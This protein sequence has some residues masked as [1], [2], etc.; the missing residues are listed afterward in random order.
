MNY[1][2]ETVDGIRWNTFEGDEHASA[3]LAGDTVASVWPNRRGGR[4]HS[5]Q[6]WGYVTG[7]GWKVISGWN[8]Q[9]FTVT[10]NGVTDSEAEARAVAARVGRAL[11]NA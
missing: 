7:Y 10:A 1:T 5:G 2:T 9:E 8:G 3:A 6:E 11:V 4:L